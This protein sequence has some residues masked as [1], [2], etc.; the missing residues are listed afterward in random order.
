MRR[1]MMSFTLMACGVIALAMGMTVAPAPTPAAAMPA[2]QPS[3]RPTLMPTAVLE[4]EEEDKDPTPVPFGRITGTV[5]DSRTGAPAAEKL[6]VVGDSVVYSDGNGNYDRWVAPG[7]YSVGLQLRSGEGVPAEG[8]QPLTVDP[9]A[10]VVHHLYFTSALPA[11]PTAEALAP[12]EAPVAV[13]AV[14]TPVAVAALPDELPDTSTAIVPASLPSTAI[15]GAAVPG[16]FMLV[17][18]LLFGV[19]ALLQVRPRRRAAAEAKAD[20]RML[21]RMLS[22]TPKQSPEETLEDLLR[23]D[24]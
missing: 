1:Q 21:R 13:L 20:A 18:A 17:G 23:R 2:L 4:E 10:T 12:T 15:G 24:V 8:M 16:A 11:T 6:V 9:G 22:S 19:G 14:P 5:I 3:P 7:V